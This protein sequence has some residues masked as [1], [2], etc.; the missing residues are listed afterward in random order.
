MWTQ[1]IY[2][3]I[4]IAASVDS[5]E[6]LINNIRRMDVILNRLLT[7]PTVPSDTDLQAILDEAEGIILNADRYWVIYGNYMFILVAREIDEVTEFTIR[8]IWHLLG[9]QIRYLAS[10]YNQVCRRFGTQGRE[11]TK[12]E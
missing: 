6:H 9:Y 10:T 1:D 12:P 8:N 5:L 4:N 3:P 11:I 7:S 2:D